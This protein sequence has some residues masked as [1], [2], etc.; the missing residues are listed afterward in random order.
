MR[1]QDLPL[2]SLL[3]LAQ[4]CK[5]RLKHDS[6]DDDMSHSVQNMET[7]S[8]E[9]GLGSSGKAHRPRAAQENCISSFVSCMQE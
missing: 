4:V 9:N 6:A 8:G 3:T 2:G 7:S 1:A 5:D